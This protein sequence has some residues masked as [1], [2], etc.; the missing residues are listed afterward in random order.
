M[1]PRQKYCV[2]SG[3]LCWENVLVWGFSDSNTNI[4]MSG[5]QCCSSKKL[6]SDM[7]GKSV[8]TGTY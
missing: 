7:G 1:L 6:V 5:S 2:L 8:S 3:N 4:P